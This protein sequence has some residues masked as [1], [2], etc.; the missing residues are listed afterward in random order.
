MNARVPVD[1]VTSTVKLKALAKPT[2]KTKKTR[3]SEIRIGYLG[4]VRVEE[5]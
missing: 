4:V 2:K 1:D 5:G 3:K